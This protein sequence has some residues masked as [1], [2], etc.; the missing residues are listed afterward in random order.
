[1]FR[2][3]FA[4]LVDGSF[5]TYDESKEAMA[6]L[7][8]SGR[9]NTHVMLKNFQYF[10]QISRE[11]AEKTG[12]LRNTYSTKMVFCLESSLHILGFIYPM[13]HVQVLYM[14]QSIFFLFFMARLP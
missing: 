1:M 8:L 9:R 2:Q 12:T 7:M 6:K 10:Y 14:H 4:A 11:Y 3:G 5:S 13:Y